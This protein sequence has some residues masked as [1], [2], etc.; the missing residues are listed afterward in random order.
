MKRETDIDALIKVT[1]KSEGLHSPDSGFTDNVMTSLQKN[2]GTAYKPLL[3]TNIFAGIFCFAVLVIAY[4]L[5]MPIDK[6]E[7]L[8]QIS[9]FK[10]ITEYLGSIS[11]HIEWPTNISYIA[12][13]ALLLLLIQVILISRVFRS[14]YR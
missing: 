9:I 8:F 3:P 2:T 4:I 1:V 13:S 11:F 10:N 12:I 7:T 5:L 14:I 6:T